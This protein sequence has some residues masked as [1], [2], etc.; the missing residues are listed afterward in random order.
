ML[1]SSLRRMTHST[2]LRAS[3]SEI[4]LSILVASSCRSLCT[5][6][7]AC[8][9]AARSIGECRRAG[10]HRQ[11][12]GGSRG[13][14]ATLR[15]G[16]GAASRCGRTFTSRRRGGNGRG[17]GNLRGG[18]SEAGAVEPLLGRDLAPCRILSA[19]PA[20]I[21]GR[22]RGTADRARPAARHRPAPAKRPTAAKTTMSRT[23]VTGT[24]PPAAAPSARDLQRPLRL[25]R[26]KKS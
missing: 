18:A 1:L 11:S 9:T 14:A 15:R 20:L 21:A 16:G 22:D 3:G 24:D 2:S 17:R 5:S 25:V 8:L 23:P 4:V 12:R 7:M 10:R 19:L 13:R 26:L 6:S